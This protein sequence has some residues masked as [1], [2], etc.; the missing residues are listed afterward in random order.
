MKITGIAFAL[1][2]GLAF[3]LRAPLLR[4]SDSPGAPLTRNPPASASC[5]FQRHSR[6]HRCDSEGARL[7]GG[8]ARPQGCGVASRGTGRAGRQGFRRTSPQATARYSARHRS[9]RRSFRAR[10]RNRRRPQSHRR[11][12]RDHAR[13]ARLAPQHRRRTRHARIASINSPA[14]TSP[15]TKCKSPHNKDCINLLTQ[16]HL[17]NAC[18]KSSN[19]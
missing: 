17:T 10:P 4:I 14:S 2:T 13:R 6:G 15:L 7:R 16:L 1:I 12:R 19:S 3:R 9:R 8:V 11:R 5:A 18:S